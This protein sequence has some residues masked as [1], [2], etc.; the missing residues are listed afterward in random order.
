MVLVEIWS[1]VMC[2]FCYIGK[3]KFESALEKFEQADGV[4]V[5][6]RSFQLD[7]AVRFKPGQTLYQYLAERKGITLEASRRMHE[8]LTAAAAEVGLRYDFDAAIVANSFDA[9]RL[10]HLA[11]EH[12][13]QEK[14][15]E[16][17]FAAYFTEGRNIGDHDT[18][19]SLGA[20]TGL[21]PAEVREML[22]GTRFAGEV[23][24]EAREAE[25]LGADGV[26]FFVFNRV[27][28]VSGAQPTELFLEALQKA[29]AD[30][31]AA[32]TGTK[33]TALS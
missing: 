29:W 11:R 9:H 30:Q 8:R 4:Q 32:G 23:R 15:E 21:D 17:L 28:S 20:E 14:I 12:G 3:R 7:P 10:T 6:W 33:T 13:A 22:A 2:P 18:L 31:R 24:K 1:D 16:R 27:L 26:P 19:V 25:S 5:T